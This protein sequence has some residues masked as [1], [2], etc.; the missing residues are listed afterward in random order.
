[1]LNDNVTFS[2]LTI[3]A[4][5]SI[6]A[7]GSSD[8]LYFYTPNNNNWLFTGTTADIG[9][10]S[11]RLTPTQI[12]MADTI[13]G[14]PPDMTLNMGGSLMKSNASNFLCSDLSSTCLSKPYSFGGTPG[15]TSFV[16]IDSAGKIATGAKHK[17]ALLTIGGSAI[18]GT[19]YSEVAS[20]P[21][22]GLVVT[23]GITPGSKTKANLQALTPINTAETYYCSD[24]AN[25]INCVSTGTVQGAFAA[26]Q[27]VNR[28]TVCN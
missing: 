5:S 26:E 21:T 19:G 18:I 23:G 28:T 24:C 6:T 9:R 7:T 13:I 17:T 8:G 15:N 4:G 20:L 14:S 25:T 12:T 27:A 1:M 3:V 16:N 22:N 2:S 11:V 10:Q